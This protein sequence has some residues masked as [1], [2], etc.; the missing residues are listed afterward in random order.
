MT[1]TTAKSGSGAACSFRLAPLALAALLCGQVQAQ[2][3]SGAV[4]SGAA[5]AGASGG[6][7]APAAPAPNPW[8]F[9]PTLDYGL[10][11]TDNV[12]LQ[13][14]A[15]KTGQLISELSPGFD[16][17]Y[18]GPRLVGRATYD[19]HLF[20]GLRR[21]VPGSRRNSH[22]LQSDMRAELVDDMLFVDAGATIN[23]VGISPFGQAPGRY[24]TANTA[25]VKTWRVSPSLRNRL[26]RFAVSEVRY[27][28]D[29]VSA[30]RSGLGD[31]SGDTVSLSLRSGQSWQ[32]L[33]FALNASDQTIRDKVR[34]DSTI[35]TGNF[36]LTY[37]LLRTLNVTAGVN[38]DNYNYESLGGANGGN[39]WNAGFTWTPS[40]RTS[41]TVNHGQR[42]YGPSRVLKGMH[43]TR[44]TVWNIS[45]DDMVTSTRANFLLP[46]AVDTAAL[47]DSLL[48]PNFPDP[49]E[50]ARA[51]EEY[52]RSTGLPPTLADQI[53][54]FSNRYSLQK[55]LRGSFA[56]RAARTTVL[57]SVYRVRREALSSSV[58]DSVLLGTSTSTVNDNVDQKGFAASLQYSLNSRS[59]LSLTTDI[60]NTESLTTGFTGRTRAVRLGL[61]QRLQKFTNARIELRHVKG[62]TGVIAPAPYSENAISAYLTMQY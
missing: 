34:N 52:I 10:I 53:N 27:T 14:D 62:A 13:R 60:Y 16:A 6:V 15:R 43:R 4:A 47:I 48:L 30:G 22:S 44:R 26:G 38:Y 58:A 57:Y 49:E 25:E 21:D 33:G 37:Q 55:Q 28:R 36:N 24:S 5:A 29:G 39:G 12:G 1:I 32:D 9:T 23:Q 46:S 2:T 41:L 40:R 51:V 56:Y 45:Y 11:L 54:F 35:Q 42:F 50:R 31:T 17:R 61:R 3:A 7:D 19:L 18:N 8:R 59:K 20:Q